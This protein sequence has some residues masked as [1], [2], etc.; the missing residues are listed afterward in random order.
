[1]KQQTKKDNFEE[2]VVMYIIMIIMLI[3]FIMVISNCFN[4]KETIREGKAL[5]EKNGMKE[6][7]TLL[8]RQWCYEE[9]SDFV[10]EYEIITD[11]WGNNPKI[12][13]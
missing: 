4:I 9:R 2:N 3:A 11:Y 13:I 8:G 12:K 7:H 10:K 6:K 1:M 5:C